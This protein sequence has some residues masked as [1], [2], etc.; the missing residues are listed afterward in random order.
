MAP[1]CVARQQQHA[2][3]L[4][5]LHHLPEARLFLWLDANSLRTNLSHCEHLITQVKIEVAGIRKQ[6]D[7]PLLYTRH[8][9]HE[10]HNRLQEFLPVGIRV[11]KWTEVL[12]HGP[13][14][15][16]WVLN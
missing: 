11:L 14:M 2:P 3:L 9:C 16:E 7:T 8:D 12:V 10:Q 1:K 4:L 15:N 6:D 5:L 13:R